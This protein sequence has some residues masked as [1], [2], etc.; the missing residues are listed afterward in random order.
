LQLLAGL[1]DADGS[2]HN[3]GYDIVLK[4]ERL[5]RDAVYLA[6]SLGFGSTI[7]PTKKKCCNSGK[8]GNYFRFSIR[9]DIRQ[10]PVI[11]KR[12]KVKNWSS[13]VDPLMSGFDVKPKGKGE[14]FGFEVGGDHLFLLGDFTV[15]HNSLLAYALARYLYDLYGWKSL[16]M[17]PKRG[18]VRQTARMFCKF[19]GDDVVIGMLGDGVK[20]IGDITVATPQTASQYKGDFNHGGFV[21]G[22]RKIARLLER[23]DVL[24][25]DE[26][27]PAGTLVHGR[28]IETVCIGDKLQTVNHAN[29]L[30]ELKQVR[31]IFR[32]RCR[33]IAKV[34]FS[35]GSSL[36]CTPS[37]P[38]YVH[39]YNSYRPAI[40]LNFGDEVICEHESDLH[41]LRQEVS[42]YMEAENLFGRM[43]QGENIAD[44]NPSG[45]GEVRLV[46]KD[47][48]VR[49]GS[50]AS[51]ASAQAGLLL[52]AM[53]PFG[54]ESA[55][56]NSRTQKLGSKKDCET[57]ARGQSLLASR[58]PRE[59]QS[60][61]APNEACAKD[62]RWERERADSARTTSQRSVGLANECDRFDQTPTIGISFTLQDRCGRTRFEDCG[63]DRRYVSLRSESSEGGC[64]QDQVFGIKRV[65]SVEI[66]ERGSSAEFETLCP[67]GEVFNLELE[68]NHNYFAGGVLVHNCHK[69]SGGEYNDI[70]MACVNAKVRWAMSGTPMTYK[71][72]KDM[73]MIGATGPIVFETGAD[74]LI[75]AGLAAKP[76]I[77]IVMSDDASGPPLR[78]KTE[79][80]FNS[81][82]RRMV[83]YRHFPK[84]QDVIS[85]Q[86]KKVLHKGAYRLSVVENQRHNL[87][88]IECVEWMVKHGRQTLLVCRMKDH[89]RTLKQMLEDRGLMYTAVWGATN[90]A[91]RDYAKK[92]LAKRRVN[93]LLVSDVFTEGESVDCIEAIVLAE[94]VKTNTSA[95]QRIG[96]GMR[97]EKGGVNDVWVVDVIPTTAPVMID[98]GLSRCLFYEGEGY[99]TR[100][101]D[102]WPTTPDD[103]ENY[104]DLLPFLKWDETVAA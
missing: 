77:A 30:V 27:F 52:G 100:L 35:D 102:F 85:R 33:S 76:K 53:P 84:Y 29:G 8:V 20:V 50:G 39:Q 65:E 92:L 51:N 103:L 18:L 7:Y 74:E 36:V 99:E 32:S 19:A 71:V 2:L 81:R 57:Y 47:C 1:I 64:A 40:S 4:S 86:T 58:S 82:S 13:R 75:G 70:L 21:P 38:I 62:S 6:R 67:R 46:Q 22:N 94:G 93:V 90:T 68:D 12:R 78:P 73:R 17:T 55:G 9:G 49:R 37:H 31:R 83:K 44:E 61:F 15:A 48:D 96:R 25:A 45:R 60:I 10:I 95:V 26:C 28:P 54:S 101:V 66:Y 80:R 63:G 14:Y 5:A 16:V 3:G 97:L 34:H 79:Y 98:H 24:I 87:T 104:D 41:Q 88:A 56:E 72:L 89:F 42:A 69:A 43:S 23:V 59:D 11:L 91:G